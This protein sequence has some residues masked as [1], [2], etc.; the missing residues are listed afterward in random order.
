MTIVYSIFFLFFWQV[1]IIY[2]QGNHKNI[3]NT[4]LTT[5]SKYIGDIHHFILLQSEYIIFNCKSK[6]SL[7]SSNNGGQYER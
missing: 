4:N 2:F 7:V 1:N 6:V 5:N 3:T